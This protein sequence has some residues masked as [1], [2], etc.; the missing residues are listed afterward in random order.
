MNTKF[1]TLQ[2]IHLALCSGVFF[3]AIITILISKDQ[4]IFDANF[5]NTS[6]FNPIFP[7][8]GLVTVF[9]SMYMFKNLISKIDSTGSLDSKITQYQSAFIVGAALLEGG[10]LINIVGCMVT[11]NAFFLIFA[12]ISF[13][14][15]VRSRPTK[16]KLV[17]DLNLQ[18]PQTDEL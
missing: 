6:P 7:I 8:I 4:L 13:F 18:Y 12:G 10:A 5:E 15:L 1:K 17:R 11:G 9:I 3:F 2:I 16:D 14:F